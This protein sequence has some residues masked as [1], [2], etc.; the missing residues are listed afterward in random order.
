MLLALGWIEGH[1]I[2]TLRTSRAERSPN[3]ISTAHA[4][5]QHNQPVHSVWL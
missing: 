3:P 1:P 2:A 4:Q 5:I